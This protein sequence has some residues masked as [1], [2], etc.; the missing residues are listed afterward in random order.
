MRN[1][2]NAY[3]PIFSVPRF[4][5]EIIIRAGTWKDNSNKSDCTTYLVDMLWGIMNFIV[6][7]AILLKVEIKSV[8]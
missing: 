1:G 5:V 3:I 8:G 2:T 7:L 4:V 6:R